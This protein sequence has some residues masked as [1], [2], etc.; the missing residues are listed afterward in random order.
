MKFPR[1]C[2]TLLIVLCTA[3]LLLFPNCCIIGAQNG[4][5]L[6]YTKVLPVLLPFFI[7]SSLIST[8]V[9]FSP[10]L[11]TMLLGVLCGY[12]MGAKNIKDYYVQGYFSKKTAQRLLCI[13]NH[14]SPMFLIG[15][16]CTMQLKN[17]LSL[18][19][20]LFAIYWPPAVLAIYFCFRHIQ[21]KKQGTQEGIVYP[22]RQSKILTL[23][24]SIEHSLLLICKIG[25]Y[26]MLYSILCNIL[27]TI[28]LTFENSALSY[29]NNL[30]IPFL[31]GILEM[32]TGIASLAQAE[33]PSLLKM[34]L[35][36]AIAS[37]GGCSSISQTHSAIKGTTLSMVPYIISKLICGFLSG[38]TILILVQI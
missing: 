22:K 7:I 27:L 3:I 32:T 4:L 2:K 37:F 23:D 13:C 8:Y 34:A 18:P 17:A 14:A 38:A 9:N 36:T 30:F 12:P 25:C 6:W 26:I 20:F 15:Y 1:W 31:T 35:I 21:E 11:T 33:A 19:L 10:I 16:V 28:G 29:W 5:L 24:E